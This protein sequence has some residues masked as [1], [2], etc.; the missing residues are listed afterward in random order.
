MDHRRT[1][2]SLYLSGKPAH[3]HFVPLAIPCFP[4]VS[5][6]M[7]CSISPYSLLSLQSESAENCDDNRDNSTGFA[8]VF[9]RTV[10]FNE[11]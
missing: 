10:N 11:L 4:F 5:L 9:D 6:D 1:S 8:H 3:E 7:P 2:F